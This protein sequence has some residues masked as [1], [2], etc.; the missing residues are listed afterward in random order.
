MEGRRVSDK[1][2]NERAGEK[3][4]NSFALSHFSSFPQTPLHFAAERGSFE[5]V[6]ILLRY[7]AAV[8]VYNVWVRECVCDSTA[9]R[10][11]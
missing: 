5:C 3:I 6:D 7:G 9:H 8:S 11:R 4:L 2:I 10:R 1:E